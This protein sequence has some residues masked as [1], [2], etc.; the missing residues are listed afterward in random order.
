MDAV[1]HGTDLHL[2][3]KLHAMAGAFRVDR[4]NHGS[5]ASSC[6]RR[7]LGLAVRDVGRSRH[8]SSR[9]RDTKP[10]HHDPAQRRSAR[11]SS[12]LHHSSRRRASRMGG[13][14]ARWAI[15]GRAPEA[16]RMGE[17]HE[18]R[19]DPGIRPEGTP[20]LRVRARG[21]PARRLK[22]DN[23]RAGVEWVSVL[24]GD[25]RHPTGRRPS[26]PHPC[27]PPA[28]S[29]P[30]HPTTSRATPHVYG[31][32]AVAPFRLSSTA[33][34]GSASKETPR[35]VA[36]GGTLSGP[37]GPTTRSPTLPNPRRSKLRRDAS[38]LQ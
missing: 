34:S 9:A 19:H 23:L 27:T 20:A 26:L 1:G 32:P 6:H 31:A 12:V 29:G 28:R 5:T 7:G 25:W 22:G 10:G 33:P 35:R 37:P 2:G 13:H 3:N 18:S 11:A 4:H 14:R 36:A 17:P 38:L 15:G 21:S 8:L 24:S 30:S 16:G